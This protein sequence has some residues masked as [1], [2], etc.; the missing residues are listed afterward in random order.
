M[1]KC[2]ICKSKINNFPIVHFKSMPLTD[3]FVKINNLGKEYLG[4]IKIYECQSCR[5][6]QNPNNFN[7][8]SYYH[9]YNYSSGHS[10]LTKKFMNKFAK[11]C[12][13]SFKK[14]NQKKPLSVIEAGS[15]D[16]EQLIYFKK[17][18][19]SKVL[20]VEPSKML[21]KESRSK[22]VPVL[23]S[24]YDDSILNK[25]KKKFDIC[26]SSYTFDHMPNPVNYL[27][28]SY[29]LLNENGILAIEIHDFEKIASR[30]EWCL[31]EHEHT[32]YLNKVSVKNLLLRYGFKVLKINP[33]PQKETR[34]NSLI[35]IAVKKFN[36]FNNY[37][38]I[39]SKSIYYKIQSLVDK[40]I[41]GIDRWISMIPEKENLIGYG[42]GGRGVM[43]LAY[44]KNIKK[45][46]AMFDSNYKV[47]NLYTPKTHIPI[48][49]IDEISLYHN[50]W[51]LVFS[52]G[53]Y[54]EIKNN[55]LSKKFSSS[56]IISL[57][58][59]YN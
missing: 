20:G 53:Y 45:F 50:S 47:D 12:I 30:P 34:A 57:K 10:I 18:K 46:S 36:F 44:L 23:R 15:G 59:F 55:L 7:Y 58:K 27:K 54:S 49:P 14:I 11:K 56:K 24:L 28:T 38:H 39:P 35:V 3:E 41:K 2:R 22:N 21:C 4:S 51:C 37:Y 19:V 32:I 13:E 40:T 16:G 6:V 8:S 48:K 9:D 42:L 5:V 33:I 52:Y 29:D 43:T 17:N 1:I 31:I 25:F 26:I